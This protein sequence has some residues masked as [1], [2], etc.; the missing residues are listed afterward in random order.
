MK[1][2]MARISTDSFLAFC[3]TLEGQE[4]L[5]RAGRSKFTVCVAGDGVEYTPLSTK[6]SRSHERKIIESVLDRFEKTGSFITTDYHDLTY[7]ASYT[8]T[9]I[10]RYLKNH[11]A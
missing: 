11:A 5:T 3:H 6:K 10:D 2:I 1:N 8:L 7:N 9:L 4:I